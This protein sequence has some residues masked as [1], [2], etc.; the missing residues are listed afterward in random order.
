MCGIAGFFH[1]STAG[2]NY[3]WSDT[4]HKMG[5]A[6]AHRGPDSSGIWADES[7]GVGLAHRRLAILDLSAAGH[8][9]MRSV[10]QRYVLVFNG[11]IYNHL[12]LRAAL[13][14]A[15][16]DSIDWRGHSDTET[17][18][19][20]FDAWGIEET[21]KR[22]IGMFAFAVWDKDTRSLVLGRDRLGEKPLYYGW[23]RGSAGHVFLFGSEL[24]A[25]KAHPAFCSDIDRSALSIYMRHGYIPA[26]YSIYKGIQKL[27]PGSLL[28]IPQAAGDAVPAPYW[29]PAQVVGMNRQDPFDGTA[30]EAVDGLHSLLRDSVAKQMLTDV[31]FGAFLSGG[32]DS[33]TIVGLMQEQCSRPVKTFTIGFQE[34]GFDEAE[35]A[36]LIAEHLGTEHYELYLT[37]GHAL[38]V[39]PLMP[40]L[41]DEPFADHTQLPNYLL[42]CMTR[43]HVTVALSG[44]AGDELFGG[45]ARYQVVDGLR[46]RNSRVPL[47]ARRALA[48]IARNLANDET[49]ASAGRLLRG[50]LDQKKFVRLAGKMRNAASVFSASN[51]V[52]LYLR[53]VTQSIDP[54]ELVV[55]GSSVLAPAFCENM[56]VDDFVHEMM[57]IDMMSYLPDD[58]LAKVDRAAMGVSLETRVPL[59]DHRIVEFAWR[60]PLAYKIR[61]GQTKW[62]IRQILYKYVPRALVDRPKKGFS[63]PIGSWLRGPL[64]DWAENLLNESRLEREGFLN[65][66]PIRRWWAEHLSGSADWQ[67]PLWNVLMFQAWLEKQ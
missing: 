15:S 1:M 6:I 30:D 13:Q 16:K 58:I 61:D 19:A 31:P 65:P 38:D 42:S 36:R 64:R 27:L 62:P 46:Q 29:D 21:V 54:L 9:P 40:E 33:T 37:P 12:D 66:V 60:L 59:L 45:Y 14:E 10:S 28:R 3:D 43:E 26:P 32:I 25:L 56:P 50:V 34:Q 52:D 8:Q 2:R 49:P 57:A 11:E 4:L 7:G 20:G 48:S 41:Y 18:L 23:Q 22:A 5:N 44:D 63:V 55:N 51:P 24:K 39:L 35:S 17:L 53:Q 67:R 47:G